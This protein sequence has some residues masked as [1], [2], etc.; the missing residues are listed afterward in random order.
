MFNKNSNFYDDFSTMSDKL[1]VNL[2]PN[3]L[4]SDLE[5]KYPIRKNKIKNF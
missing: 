3:I 2:K 4:Y 1:L 5:N